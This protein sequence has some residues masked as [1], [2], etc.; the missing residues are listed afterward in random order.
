M[1][2]FD[3]QAP[4]IPAFMVSGT[5]GACLVSAARLGQELWW[6]L[7]VGD[8]LMDLIAVFRDNF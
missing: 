8:R 5:D 1:G 3:E 4:S 7:L 2:L 6:H